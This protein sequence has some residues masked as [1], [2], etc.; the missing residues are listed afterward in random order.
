MEDQALLE[1]AINY[2]N[3]NVSALHKSGEEPPK[4]EN[5][6]GDVTVEDVMGHAIRDGEIH[7]VVNRGILG[8]P[9]YRIAL[10]KLETEKSKSGRSAKAKAEAKK[11]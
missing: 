10:D 1:A 3:E 8:A 6:G 5:L 4:K 9:K 2:V 7:L 11:E